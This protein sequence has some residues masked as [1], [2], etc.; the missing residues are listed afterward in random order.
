[1]KTEAIQN[2]KK[3][4]AALEAKAD[5]FNKAHGKR[6]KLSQMKQVFTNAAKECQTNNILEYSFARINL[7]LRIASGNFEVK[8]FKMGSFG[9]INFASSIELE[10]SDFNKAAQ[11]I[12][13]F[14]LDFEVSS[15]DD[16]YLDHKPLSLVSSFI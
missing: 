1:M 10:Q 2:S 11:D 15:I 7:F 3:I 8:A 16:L 13:S 5:S 9:A 4:I 6:I 12:L 14:G